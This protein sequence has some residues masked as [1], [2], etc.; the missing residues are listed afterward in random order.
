[1]ACRGHS[2]GFAKHMHMAV[3]KLKGLEARFKPHA[4]TSVKGF[5]HRFN[6]FEKTPACGCGYLWS[7]HSNL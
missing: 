1:M 2:K 7:F 4:E 5:A 6:G 3:D